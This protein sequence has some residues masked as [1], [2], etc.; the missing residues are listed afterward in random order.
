MSDTTA[1]LAYEKPELQRFGTFR[2]LT[3]AGTGGVTCDPA[4][5][6]GPAPVNRADDLG[7]CY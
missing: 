7:R 2:E 3:Q 6:L 4:F 1:R 5:G